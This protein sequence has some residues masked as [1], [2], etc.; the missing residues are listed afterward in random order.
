MR[1]KTF[2][3][4]IIGLVWLL[5]A[6]PGS[7]QQKDQA[8]ITV[9]GL[10][11]A[12]TTFTLEQLRQMPQESVSLANPNPNTSEQYEGVLLRTLLAKVDATIGKKLHAD[13]LRDYVEVAGRDGYRVVFALAELDPTLQENKILV[14]ISNE[15]KPLDNTLGP[16]RLIAPQDKR[17]AR[18]VRQVTTITLRQAP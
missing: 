7:A 3:F 18:S 16:V 4:L 14:A 8:S 5:C 15:G 17:Q 6:A 10:D 9:E 11:G 2:T 12:K 1:K 13:D